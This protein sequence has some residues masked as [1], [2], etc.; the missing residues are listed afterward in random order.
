MSPPFPGAR[1]ECVANCV[2]TAATNKCA[3]G[4]GLTRASRLSSPRCTC[5]KKAD[6][7]VTSKEASF[8][9]KI[10]SCKRASLLLCG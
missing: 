3:K 9:G 7:I 6:R 8:G 4:K 5:H 2:D 1:T 10:A